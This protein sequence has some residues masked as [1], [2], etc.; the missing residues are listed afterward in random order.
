MRRR[1]TRNEQKEEK[2]KETEN[3][4]ATELDDYQ[5]IVSQFLNKMSNISIINQGT[6]NICLP[7]F[8]PSGETTSVAF[9]ILT[10]TETHGVKRHQIT[11][12]DKKQRIDPMNDTFQFGSRSH[13]QKET[14]HNTQKSNRR[15]QNENKSLPINHSMDIHGKVNIV[16]PNSI[17]QT[18]GLIRTTKTIDVRDVVD[19][20]KELL[21]KW[22]SLDGC[23]V[24]YDS[25]VDG[26]SASAFNFC[27]HE[28]Q[29]LMVIVIT[30][31][32]NI[33]GSFS[34]IPFP[35]EINGQK[36]INDDPNFF[37]FSLINP[38]RFKVKS[39]KN[40]GIVVFP[41]YS[42]EWIFATKN[43]FSLRLNN[44]SAM[45]D[46][47]LEFYT[48]VEK[49]SDPIENDLFVMG[50]FPETFEL[51]KVIVLEWKD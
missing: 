12:G 33:F 8:Q 45:S 37:V 20:Y 51:S 29:N 28:K 5:Q 27:C 1:T 14:E 17:Y 18:E 21:S 2:E 39:K 10:A 30:S 23:E 40:C 9:D 44:K 36:E 7:I 4:Q 42:K 16:D 49:Y 24:I 35:S 22:T 46:K 38:M 48:P 47:F 41:N 13:S 11:S 15:N 26:L 31:M 32:G 34:S 25:L 3:Q 19:I 50:V 6:I 43:C